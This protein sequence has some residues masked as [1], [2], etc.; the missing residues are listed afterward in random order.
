MLEGI[1]EAVHQLRR[2][3][4][5]VQV[6]AAK[7][8]ACRL[9]VLLLVGIVILLHHGFFCLPLFFLSLPLH[10]LIMPQ[11][12]LLLEYLLF[13]HA[14]QARLMTINQLLFQSTAYKQLRI[15]ILD[16]IR[17]FL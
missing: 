9:T 2:R 3:G 10:R 14:H 8:V 12:L 4:H 5:H 7:G 16:E 11:Q 15:L 6:E 13:L 17:Q 1:L